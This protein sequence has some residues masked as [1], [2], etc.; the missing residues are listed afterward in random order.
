MPKFLRAT[1]QGRWLNGTDDNKW[2]LSGEIKADALRDLETRGNALSVFR[3][4]D[5]SAADKICLALAATKDGF[6]NVDYAIFD[7]AELSHIGIEPTQTMGETPDPEVNQLHHD[8]TMLTVEKVSRLARI[9]AAGDHNRVLK[10]DI[11]SSL[12]SAVQS[13]SLDKNRINSKLLKRLESG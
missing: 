2:L 13:N 9:V 6:A 4:D 8:L 3:A 10:R 7:G 11:E 5:E 12:Q 1:R